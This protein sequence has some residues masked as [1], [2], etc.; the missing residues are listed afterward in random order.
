MRAVVQRVDGASVVVD[1]N[2]VGSFEGPGLAVLVGVS[3]DDTLDVCAPMA[4]KIWK[5]RIFS[6]NDLQAKGIAVHADTNEVAAA[7]AN[8]P[9]MIISQ[10]TLYADTT[11]G[12]RPTWQ[13]AAR[14]DQAEPLVNEL[15]RALRD[16]GARVETGKFGA[17]MRITQTCDGPVTILL[18]L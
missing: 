12:R 8:L 7:D 11:R 14:G 6:S 17:D 16:L 3:V 5:L 1:G 4:E 2:V 9:V 13:Q 18:D 15:A 10:F